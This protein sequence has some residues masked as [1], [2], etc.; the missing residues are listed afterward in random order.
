LA[1][2]RLRSTL[3][4]L[5]PRDAGR[6]MLGDAAPWYEDWLDNCDVTDPYWEPV[7]L[8]EALEN[9]RIPVLISTGWQ[10]VFLDQSLYQ[11]RRLRDRG[12]EVALTVGPW[13]HLDV[14]GRGSARL[15]AEALDWLGAHLAE[16]TPSRRR[17]PVR[18]CVTGATQWRDLPDWP[19]PS[20]EKMLYLQPGA[21]L[22]DQ[23]PPADAAPSQF[24]YDPATPTPT[25]G[26]RLLSVV[27]GYHDDSMLADRGDVLAFTS[28]PLSEALEVTGTP[29]VE[30]EHRSDTG[31]ADVFVRIS[32]VDAR[33]RSCNVSDGYVRI[34]GESPSPLRIMLDAIAHRFSAGNRIRLLVAGGSH[35]RFARNLGT[36]EPV[37][38]GSRIATTTHVVAHGEGGTSRLILPVPS[39]EP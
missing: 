33:G 32:E 5:P 7:N 35:P 4:A 12:V 16:A 34:Q 38:T 6:A 28:P 36:G 27:A 39:P 31:F 30:L 37:A 25:I 23:C 9:A 13:S 15:T 22:G 1:Q 8:A 18:I 2:W 20:G 21:V 26:G 24:T 3:R 11:Y 19:P 14:G 29:A 17:S 10:D